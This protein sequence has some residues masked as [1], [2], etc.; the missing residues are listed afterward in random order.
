MDEKPVKRGFVGFGDYIKEKS[1]EIGVDYFKRNTK[2][3]E[4]DLTK[5]I[6]KV[7]E[8]KIKKEVK[9]YTYSIF[10]IVFLTI[11]SLFILFGLISM[12]TY[13][14]NLPTYMT[15]L[16]FGGIILMIS[17]VFFLLK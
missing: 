10:S 17:L 11:S 5:Y 4:K 16:I 9:K 13:G 8:R 2:F 1:V 3:L 14:A 12:F 7:I 6:E 15:S